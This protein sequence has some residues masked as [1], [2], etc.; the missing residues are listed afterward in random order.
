MD[1]PSKRRGP[2]AGRDDAV[3]F[4]GREHEVR[5]IEEALGK[6]ESMLISGPVDIGKTALIEHVLR[7]LPQNLAGRCLYLSNFKDL[8]DLLRKLLISLYQATNPALRRQLY[9]EGVSATNFNAWLKAKPTPRL[10][11][12]SHGEI[13]KGCHFRHK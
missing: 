6:K 4:L 1:N 5:R 13:E 8:R 11:R 3:C 2:G 12:E 9:A 7:G 10:T